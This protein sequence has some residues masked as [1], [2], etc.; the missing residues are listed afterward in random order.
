MRATPDIAHLSTPHASP[1]PL[2][3]RDHAAFLDLDGTLVE[4]QARPHAVSASPALRALLRRLNERMAGALAIV[5]GRSLG[6][7]DDI[8]EGAVNHAAGVHGFEIQRGGRISRDDVEQAR[9]AEARAEVRQLLQ[10]RKLPAL[11]EDKHAS[12]ALHYRQNPEAADAIQHIAQE[13]AAKHGLRL[14]HGKMVV[15][16]N[17][18]ARTKGYAVTVLMAAP[19]FTGRTPVALG[20]DFTDEDAFAAAKRMGGFGVLV[21]EPRRTHA[22]F[23]L[24][25]PAAVARWLEAGLRRA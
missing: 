9:L 6:D 22:D 2:L 7:L 3:V 24:P 8:I 19:P 12:L 4:I 13:L 10:R 1:P 25:D 5:T 23:T 15:E 11:V 14:V 16:L 20:D 18:S 21:G 17:A